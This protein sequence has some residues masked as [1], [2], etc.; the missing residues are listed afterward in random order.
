GD[1]QPR[2]LASG[3]GHGGDCHAQ[4]AIETISGGDLLVLP[5]RP[6]ASGRSRAVPKYAP[7]NDRRS[8]GAYRRIASP[9]HGRTRPMGAFSAPGIVSSEES[10]CSQGGNPAQ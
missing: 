9:P 5:P 1:E 10:R 7:C 6:N 8:D 3:L 4:P 2:T